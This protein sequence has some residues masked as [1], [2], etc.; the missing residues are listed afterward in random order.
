MAER[1][2][3]AVIEKYNWNQDGEVLLNLYR[4]LLPK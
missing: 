2:R 1:G 3:K 4:K